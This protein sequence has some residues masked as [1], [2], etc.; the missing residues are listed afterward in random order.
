LREAMLIDG[1]WVQAE[2]GQ[3]IEVRNP[4]T[5]ELVARVPNGGERETQRA[6]AAAERAMKSWRKTLPK[7]RSKVL[8]KLFDLMLE[9]ID[10]LAIIMT[11]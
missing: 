6:V 7:E 2:N 11:A 3:T 1:Q 4:A 5:G 8:R 9:N 10:D